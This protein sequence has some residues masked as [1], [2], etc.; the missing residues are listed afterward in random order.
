MVDTESGFSYYVVIKGKTNPF[1]GT[2]GSYALMSARVAMK[3]AI[4]QPEEI[5][6]DARRGRQ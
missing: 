5:S 6:P 1:M 3:G 2:E 4:T